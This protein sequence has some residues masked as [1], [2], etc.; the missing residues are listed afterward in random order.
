MVPFQHYSVIRTVVGHIFVYFC[1]MIQ[2]PPS[3]DAVIKCDHLAYPRSPLVIN[4]DHL[5]TPLPPPRVIAGYLNGL[6]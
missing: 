3:C 4:S 2:F 6:L 1:K 5:A